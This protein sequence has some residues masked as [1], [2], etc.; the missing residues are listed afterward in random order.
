MAVKKVAATRSKTVDA[1][2]TKTV[3]SSRG[4]K[5]TKSSKT[6]RVSKTSKAKK[7]A[8][9]SKTQVILRGIDVTKVLLLHYGV[10]DDG[11]D[12]GITETVLDYDEYNINDLLHETGKKSKRST[13]FF[14]PHKGQIKMWAVMADVTENGPLPRRTNKPCWWCR[15]K[16]HTNPIG[17][18]IKY[19]AYGKTPSKTII[20]WFEENNIPLK[21]RDGWF[22]TEGVFCMFSCVK[23]YILNELSRTKSP[24][25]KKSLTLLT[26]LYSKLTGELAVI[27]R[28]G[29]WKT[30]TEWGGHMT[31]QEYRASIGPLEYTETV[32]VRRPYMFSTSQ[33]IQERRLKD[34]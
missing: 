29:T 7:P 23:A 17:C 19:T 34:E 2:S 6:E 25:Y 30:T 20:R 15:C 26:L 24:K 14:D 3:K 21:D 18:P 10:D 12:D 31:P 33:Y 32:N 27:P 22:E 28:S 11:E 9:K 5:T 8:P 16:F 13:M 4:V 1:K